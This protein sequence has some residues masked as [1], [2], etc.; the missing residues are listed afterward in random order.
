MK[1]RIL[2]AV[3]SLALGA[4]L[5]MG[6]ADSGEDDQ[7]ILDRYDAGGDVA[8]QGSETGTEDTDGLSPDSGI[9]G[10]NGEDYDDAGTPDDGSDA[11]HVADANG[12]NDGICQ[13]AGDGVIRRDRVPLETGQSAP[14]LFGLDVPVNTAG[15]DIEGVRTWDLSAEGDGDFEEEVILKDPDDFWFGEVFPDATYATA[16]SAD[17]DTDELG[18]FEVTDDALLLV[19]LASP[20]DGLYR[21]EL[22][23]DPPVTVLSFPFEEGDQWEVETEAEG[24]FGGNHFHSHDEVYETVVDA[25]GDM[26]TPY[27]T[28]PVLRVNT[29]REQEVW[30]G[31]LVWVTTEVRTM[32]FVSEC[33]GT[34]AR[35]ISEED[36][37]E[38]E[39]DHAAEVM[40]LSL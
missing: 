32:A 25:A 36:E 23:Y 2:G 37:E 33:F 19:G 11:Q 3:T 31:G 29:L 27:G 38:E 35:I 4:A 30:M 6:C 40:R 15:E 5:V 14:F 24:S 21:T 28:F 39:F 12:G 26:I 10:D 16:L 7:R 13:P 17:D 22:T 8:V 1:V 18:V 9:D 20:D 34:V